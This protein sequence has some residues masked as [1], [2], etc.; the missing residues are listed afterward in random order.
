MIW[1]LF[2]RLSTLNTYLCV[3]RMM[4]VFSVTTGSMMILS[5][6]MLRPL[7]RGVRCVP[8]PP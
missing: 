3:S 1:Y 8:G 6:V 7:V 4:F 2:A 5:I